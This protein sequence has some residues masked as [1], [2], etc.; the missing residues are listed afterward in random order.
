MVELS[1]KPLNIKIALLDVGQGDTIVVSCPETHE[2][3]VVDCVNADAVL[4]Y[5][6]QEQIKYF[7]GIIITHLHTNHYSEVDYLL[8]RS[9]LV[10]GMSECE[11]L[12]F[13]QLTDAKN[14]YK[15]LLD[16]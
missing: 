16:A 2:A 12:G 15:L 6:E 7:R 14:Y 4:E 9:N 8:Y 10:P 5:L 11:K 1:K 13:S 3:I